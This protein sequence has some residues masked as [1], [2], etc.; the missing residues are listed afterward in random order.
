DGIAWLLLDK[1]DASTNTL[2]ENVLIELDAVL[3][4]IEA[5]RPRGMVIRSAKQ[6]GFV[7]GADID[8][9]RGVTDIAA[10]EALLTRGHAVFDRLDRLPLPTVAVIHGFC[11]GGGLELALACEYRVAIDSA[12]FG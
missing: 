7:A 2:S 3:T 5:D 1:K 4:K 12:S 9:F 11:L 8:Q 10:I 6:N